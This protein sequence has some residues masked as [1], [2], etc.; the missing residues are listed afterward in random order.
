M[1]RVVK[2]KAYMRQTWVIELRILGRQL[3]E[4]QDRQGPGWRIFIEAYVRRKRS[5]A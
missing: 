4:G 1:G 2:R 3:R 5:A